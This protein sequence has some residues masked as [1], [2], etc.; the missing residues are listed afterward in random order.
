ML[1]YLEYAGRYGSF[2]MFD[3]DIA[4]NWRMVGCSEFGFYGGKIVFARV[5]HE[6]GLARS[7]LVKIGRLNDVYQWN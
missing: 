5:F 7:F 3:G 6:V 4:S 1:V 2:K